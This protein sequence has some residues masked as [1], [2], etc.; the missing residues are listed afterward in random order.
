MLLVKKLMVPLSEYAT[1][2]DK[3][4]LF[5]AALALE[6]AQEKYTQ[7]TYQHRAVLIMDSKK[8]VVGKLSQ[9]DVIRALEPEN[10]KLDEL[11]DL[12]KFGFGSG[13]IENQRKQLKNGGPSLEHILPQT[14]QLKVVDFMQSVS[15][16]EYVD[17]NVSLDVAVHHLLMGSHLSLLVTRNGIIAGILRLSDVFAAVFNAMKETEAT[18]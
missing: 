9:L 8:K 7:S 1:V 17:E 6:K 12:Q 16:G 15:A 5:E 4:T 2:S 13:F 14:A 3:A 18:K 11:T 10:E